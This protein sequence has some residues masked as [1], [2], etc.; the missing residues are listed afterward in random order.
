[1]HKVKIEDLETG[2]VTARSVE[3]HNGYRILAKGTVLTERQIALLVD[4]KVLDVWVE[5][6]VAEPD[7]LEA[8]ESAEEEALD[9]ARERLAALFEGRETNAWM[10]ALHEEAEKRLAVGR[11]W[12]EQV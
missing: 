3:D 2:K 6:E 1:M 4:W 12:Q 8:A 11:F 9:K 5:D 7:E 10:E